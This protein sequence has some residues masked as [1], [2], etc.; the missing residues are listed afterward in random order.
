[1]GGGGANLI[2][3]I[4]QVYNGDEL[5]KTDDGLENTEENSFELQ[6]I[7]ESREWNCTVTKE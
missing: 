1:M 6:N 3:Q 2:N 7:E 4:R 5:Q